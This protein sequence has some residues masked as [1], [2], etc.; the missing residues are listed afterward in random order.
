M[1]TNNPNDAA[2]AAMLEEAAQTYSPPAGAK[3]AVKAALMAKL[4]SP[5]RVWFRLTKIAAAAVICLAVLGLWWLS[6]GPDMA[7]SAYAELL[8]AVDN[9]KAAEWLHYKVSISGQEAEAWMSFQP[10]RAFSRFAGRVASLDSVAGRQYEYDPSTRTLTVYHWKHA[11]LEQSQDFFTAMTGGLEE[12]K[13]EGSKVSKDTELVN[14]KSYMVY[15]VEYKGS[16]IRYI[17]DPSI[18]RL[19][20]FE[21]SPI[22]ASSGDSQSVIA[23]VD[24]PESG[25][26]DVYALGVPRDAKIVDNTLPRKESEWDRH[27]NR[28]IEIID[29][30]ADWPSTPEEVSRVYWEARAAKNYDEMAVLW[31]GSALWNHKLRDEK[32]GKYVF[33]KAYENP[34]APEYMHVPYAPEG[35][36]KQ[37]GR[38]NLKMV[39]TNKESTKGRYY[40]FSGN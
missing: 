38:Y 17:V 40:I 23:N 35:Y 12:H 34:R 27:F 4:A 18:Q 22:N 5:R 16:R 11:M 8:Q 19:V 1:K 37:Q 14:G 39:L 15:T 32:P 26:A 9:T 13:P 20:R 36:Y 31:P 29:K 6:T 33:G 3:Q 7:N 28:A 21:V 10:F 2:I 30:R 25:P 24:Y